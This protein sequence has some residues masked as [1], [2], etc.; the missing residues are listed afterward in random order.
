MDATGRAAGVSDRVHDKARAAAVEAAAWAWVAAVAVLGWAVA[1]AAAIIPRCRIIAH[2]WQVSARCPN[3]RGGRHWRSA[4][5][6]A[7]TVL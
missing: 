6:K 2:R 1:S 3:R 4:E 7:V 5:M